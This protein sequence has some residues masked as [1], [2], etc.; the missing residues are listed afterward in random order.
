M[1]REPFGQWTPDLNPMLV[2]GR[3]LMVARNVLPSPD[4]YVPFPSL[5]P[6]ALFAV[7][8]RPKSAIRVRT[9]AG[10]SEFFAGGDDTTIPNNPRARIWRLT[11]AGWSDVSSAIPYLALGVTRWSF[12]QF[13]NFV[14]ACQRGANTQVFEIGRSTTFEDLRGAVPRAQHSA[15]A[16]N[17][18][19]LAD[20]ADPF[21]GVLR[22]AVAWGPLGSP[23]DWPRHG[24]D[25]ATQ[26]QSGQQILEGEGGAV[27]AVKAG[28]EVVAVFQESAIW[29]A[30]YVGNEI[31]WQ[32]NRVVPDSGLLIKD[33]AVQFERGIFYIAPDGFRIF[34]FTSSQ[35]IG[36]GRVN[37]W[38][39]ADYDS[40]YP[41]SVTVERD[42]VST[43]VLVSYAG[44]GNVGGIPN[45]LIVWDWMLDKFSYCEVVHAGLLGAQES[46]PSLDSPGTVD[47]PSLLGDGQPYGLDSF[48]DRPAGLDGVM[49]G[50]FDATYQLARFSGVGLEATLETGDM[51]IVPGRRATLKG[52]APNL[53]S[54]EIT[55]QCAGL[56]NRNDPNPVYEFGPRKELEDDGFARFEDDWRIHRL[57]FNLGRS[58][59]PATAYDVEARATG[60]F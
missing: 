31:V 54:D 34:N 37:D 42:P 1:A 48:D 27:Q 22:N 39:F 2:Q 45:R 46:S 40:T 49:I 38:F 47:D 4:G 15:V 59:T 16:E 33:A 11:E 60:R 25:E 17:F 14:I 21:D 12:T 29:R 41:D 20:L 24:T 51:E 9:T 26:V 7:P 3:G 43:R 23:N 35:N 10:T 50:A 53:G 56:D 52:V 55:I 44:Q 8:F 18:L 13:S 32:F 57:R 36:K 28:A 19:W 58:F 6:V 5:D 30:D